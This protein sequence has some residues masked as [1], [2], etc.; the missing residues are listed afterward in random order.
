MSMF[1][2][3]INKS[4]LILT[5]ILWTSL[6][7]QTFTGYSPRN[8]LFL[9]IRFPNSFQAFRSRQILILGYI[10]LYQKNLGLKLL[11]L[12]EVPKDRRCAGNKIRRANLE[13]YQEE[14]IPWPLLLICFLGRTVQGWPSCW[15]GQNRLSHC[16]G[17]DLLRCT[18]KKGVA[19]SFGCLSVCPN[20]HWP[21]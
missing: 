13:P 16:A 8:R 15:L 1:N 12:C 3:P 7:I 2:E 5:G 14:K 19:I 20:C 21:Y 4:A 17:T 10:F 6:V 9:G 11:V 18:G